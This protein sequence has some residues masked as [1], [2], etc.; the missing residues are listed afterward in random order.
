[1]LDVLFILALRLGLDRALASSGPLCLTKGIT[2]YIVPDKSRKRMPRYTLYSDGLL[3]DGR[4]RL[5]PIRWPL[6]T[7]TIL[8]G[9]PITGA[10]VEIDIT[11]AD[12][13]ITG[14]VPIWTAS[15]DMKRHVE[16]L[17]YQFTVG[18]PNAIIFLRLRVL[19]GTR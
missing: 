4:G 5:W 10:P 16:S 17:L 11:V 18:T 13:G 9:D 15:G 8:Q 7:S 6:F 2:V 14:L 19:D 12:E 1:M 3:R